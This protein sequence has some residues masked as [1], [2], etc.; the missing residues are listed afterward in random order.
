MPQQF[1]SMILHS[2]IITQLLIFDLCQQFPLAIFFL[3]Y[4]AYRVVT[5]LDFVKLKCLW[6][7]VY[8]RLPDVSYDRWWY[9]MKALS[10]SADPDLS[11]SKT[12][13]GCWSFQV[14]INKTWVGDETTNKNA[15]CPVLSTCCRMEGNGPHAY[16]NKNTSHFVYP[17]VFKGKGGTKMGLPLSISG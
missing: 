14:T 8:S 4:M 9:I 1:I 12:Y 6:N 13:S 5:S 11:P 2:N 7:I 17:A 16:G 15:L 10:P 3:I